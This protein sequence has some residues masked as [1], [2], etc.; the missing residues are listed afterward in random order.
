MTVERT[1]ANAE[2]AREPA[3]EPKPAADCR[4]AVMLGEGF[5]TIEALTSVDVLRRAGVEVV[6]VSVMPTREVASAQGVTVVAD[7]VAAG[8][9]AAGAAAG[10]LGESGAAAAALGAGADASIDLGGFDAI[11]LPGGMGGYENLSAC[12]PLR[13]AL[14]RQLAEGRLVAAICAAPMLLAHLG[15]LDGRRATCYPGCEDVFPAGAYQPDGVVRDGSLVTG[16]GP[17]KS[18]PFA[19]AVLAALAGEDAAA[20][21]A[22]DML[23][24]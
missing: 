16:S 21:V 1:E 13:A 24:C 5:E 23:A 17:A 18:L 15:L 11:I 6:T 2:A 12:A 8:G 3:W 9:A 7:A 4:V 14:A 19:L 20:R 10:A 22:A